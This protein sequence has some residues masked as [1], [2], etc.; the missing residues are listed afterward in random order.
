MD[1]QKVLPLVALC[2]NHKTILGIIQP[3]LS[4]NMDTNVFP[5]VVVFYS[6]LSRKTFRCYR[7]WFTIYLFVCLPL[8]GGAMEGVTLHSFQQNLKL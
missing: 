3:K 2:L 6:V 1:K 4:A 5:D 7:V 8:K